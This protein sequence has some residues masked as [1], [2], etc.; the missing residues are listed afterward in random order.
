[1]YAPVAVALASIVFGVTAGQIGAAATSEKIRQRQDAPTRRSRTPMMGIPASVEECFPWDK[2]TY[3][4]DDIEELWEAVVEAYGSEGAAEAAVLQ[5]RGQ[6]LCPVYITP[7]MVQ[8]S[9]AALAANLGE[10]EA[11]EIMAKNPCILTCGE[12]L[13]VADPAEIRRLAQFRFYFDKIP[14]AVL[15]GSVLLISAAVLAKILLIRFGY[16]D[17]VFT[18]PILK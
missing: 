7:D 8:E 14:P 16:S 17:P 6:I 9:R 15:L 12:S 10:E 5:V 2:N 4:P 18:E 11:S 13:E 1:V 3:S